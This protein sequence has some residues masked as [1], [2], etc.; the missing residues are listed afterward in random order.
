MRKRAGFTLVELLV[1]MA[2]ISLIAG[3]VVPAVRRAQERA[4]QAVCMSNLRQLGQAFL[5]YASDHDGLLPAW[6]AITGKFDR[7]RVVTY[8]GGKFACWHGILVRAGYLRNP[9]VLLCPSD[10]PSAK[11]RGC[12]GYILR[13]DATFYLCRDWIF[14]G[15]I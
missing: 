5:T 3:L 11:W 8:D 7:D 6:F 1:V 2:I 10:V 12:V 9:E 15:D 4:K 14:A 13:C